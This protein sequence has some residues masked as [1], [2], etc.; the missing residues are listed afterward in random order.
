LPSTRMYFLE[1]TGK[2]QWY[3][4]YILAT[5]PPGS[6]SRVRS[7]RTCFAMKFRCDSAVSTLIPRTLTFRDSNEPIVC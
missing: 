2:S 4:P 6:E 7:L 1:A 3:A 5:L